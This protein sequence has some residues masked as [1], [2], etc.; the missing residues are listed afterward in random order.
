[1]SDQF[2]WEKVGSVSGVQLLATARLFF[3]YYFLTALAG[4]RAVVGLLDN[5]I[6]LR[7]HIARIIFWFL[8]VFNG[9]WQCRHS[10]VRSR[11]RRGID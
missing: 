1:V 5:K 7:E 4:G 9:W 3:G 8:P 10:P 11:G 2:S 6:S